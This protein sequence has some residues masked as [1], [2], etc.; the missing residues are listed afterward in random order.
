MH[1]TVFLEPASLEPRRP[2][3]GRPTLT[4]IG[5]DG[6]LSPPPPPPQPSEVQLWA[7]AA[8]NECWLNDALIY[9]GKATDWF[10]IYKT[11]ECLIK[12]SGEGKEKD[13]F[14]LKWVD[15]DEIV[16]LKWTA[17]WVAR[18]ARRK[19]QRP[20]KPMELP[21]ARRLVGQLLRR[22]L[23]EAAGPRQ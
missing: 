5:P 22:A 17:N 19:F 16:R 23:E 15:E 18:H 13:F 3:F 4:A 11:L 20:P 14:A 1:K 9:L 21:E 2:V 12:K 10:D 8:D 7:M 6:Q